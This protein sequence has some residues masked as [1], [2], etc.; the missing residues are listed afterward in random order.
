MTKDA[1]Q[2]ANKRFKIAHSPIMNVLQLL[3]LNSK[4]NMSRNNIQRYM[5]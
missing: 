1:I 2:K 4:R 5:R 3:T